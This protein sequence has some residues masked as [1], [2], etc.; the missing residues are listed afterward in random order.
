VFVKKALFDILFFGAGENPKKALNLVKEKLLTN[1]GYKKY[2]DSG[3]IGDRTIRVVA[4]GTFKAYREWKIETSGISLFQ[5]KVPVTVADTETK[6]WVVRR[7]IFE[8]EKV[9]LESRI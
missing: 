2:S 1:K 9:S 8:V 3:F 5:I 7:V 4:P 6:D